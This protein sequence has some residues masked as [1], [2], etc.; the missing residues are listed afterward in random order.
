VN[1]IGFHAKKT[2]WDSMSEAASNP[3]WYLAT[4]RNDFLLRAM[5]AAKDYLD[6][7]L[8]LSKPQLNDLIVSDWIRLI[9]AVLVLGAFAGQLDAPT[10]D[11]TYARGIADVQEYLRALI[12]K[13]GG[14]AP[15]SSETEE[16]PYLSHVTGLFYYYYHHY[17]SRFEIAQSYAAS[18]KV[19]AGVPDF[20]FTEVLQ[21]KVKK[22]ADWEEDPMQVVPLQSFPHDWDQILESWP[23]TLDPSAITIESSAW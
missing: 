22:C 5:H 23:D 14:V 1:E 20:S 8:G 10:L 21:I 15:S 3:P 17:Q 11:L 16:N 9:Y 6:R 13:L 12:T 7:F 2:T 19:H 18:G 4:V